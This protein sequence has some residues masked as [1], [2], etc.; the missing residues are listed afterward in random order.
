MLAEAREAASA[1]QRVPAAL[2]R[3]KDKA[4]DPPSSISSPP[5]STPPRQSVLR[6][7]LSR[8]REMGDPIGYEE[9]N[10]IIGLPVIPPMTPEE[11]E[12]FNRTHLLA[13]ALNSGFRLWPAQC[14]AVQG[15]ENVGGLFAPIGVGWGKTLI[16]QMIAGV[17]SRKGLKRTMLLLPSQVLHQLVKQDFPSAR[18]RVPIPYPVHVFGEKT[19]AE[20]RALARSQKRGLYI[21][22]YSLLSAKDA[23]DNLRFVAPELIICDEADAL[24][25]RKAARTK[26][27]MEF[28]REFKPQG[29][30][31]SGTITSKSIRD[32]WHLI[33][34]CLGDGCP[35]PLSSN[36]ASEWASKI[37][38]QVSSSEASGPIME[39]VEWAIDQFPQEEIT[40]DTT[41]F[42]KAYKLRL[43]S[44][45]G[46]VSTGDAD[47]GPSLVLHNEKVKE[48]QTVEGWARL[49][50]L[51]LQVVEKYL[52]P[53]LD[54]I[55]H[56]IHAYKWLYELT[57]GFYNELIFPTPEQFSEK[58][59]VTSGTAEEILEMAKQSHTAQQ[60]YHRAL[61][62]WLEIFS[63]A[64]LDTPMLVAHSMSQYQAK[65]VGHDLYSLWL[66]HKEWEEDLSSLLTA[67]G[68]HH[69]SVKE[70]EK[71]VSRSLRFD[72]V[73]RVCPYKILAAVEWAKRHKKTGGIVWVY[74]K[75]IGQWAY[76]E[77]RKAGLDPLYC[78]AGKAHNEAITNPENRGRIIVASMRAH[79]VGKNLQS[80]HQQLFLQWPR[81]AK[82]A[83][84]TLGR[85]HRN[86]QLQSEV[87]A[88][89]CNTM[90]FDEL[91]FA[92][93]L[94]DA[95]YIHQTTGN[96]QKL[97]YATYS[98]DMPK[99]YP[100]GLLRERG[101]QNRTLTQEQRQI[102]AERFGENV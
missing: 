51:R 47:I 92:A 40:E 36:L 42:R 66:D 83:E 50:E 87:W 63:R 78:P 62:G 61:R 59:N 19:I 11:V 5:P 82:T 33:K 20:R 14:R 44:A 28:V 32:Y 1:P 15:Y 18:K 97:I 96:R 75:G 48:R 52:T 100:S 95:L 94:N 17:A 27:L 23:S 54:E 8:A 84:Q 64:N 69:G 38:A 68:A 24:A 7:K 26:R 67:T 9:L 77:L 10:R 76:E 45:P 3:R 34:W 88:H 43:Q 31:L 74:H 35:L 39:L 41:G 102:M 93:T 98:P 53:N 2:A 37:D 25:S 70:L 30:C 91:C 79:G 49:E 46:V 85:M 101:F 21:M 81:S 86:G 22:P 80:F 89:T 60:E 58:E 55:E 29:A 65:Y 12:E 16:T 99:I 4:G 6:D 57:A 56:A 73:V 90:E 13:S 71:R 72:R